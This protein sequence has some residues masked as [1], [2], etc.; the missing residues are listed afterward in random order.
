[1][2]N[3]FANK[4]EKPEDDV[5][6]QAQ[7]RMHETAW[8][9]ARIGDITPS[10][11]A[12]TSVNI[13]PGNVGVAIRWGKVLDDPMT[14]GWQLKM[15]YTDVV[16]LSTKLE[17]HHFEMETAS[18]DLQVVTTGITVPYS[19]DPDLAPKVYQK[20]GGPKEIEAAIITPAILES[21]K[22][23]NSKYTAEEL[24][25]KRAEVKE[26]LE[27]AFD[28]FVNK[29]LDERGLHNAL[30]L[31][32]LAITDSGFTPEFNKAIEAKVQADQAALQAQYEKRA[33]ITAAEAQAEKQKLAAD[34]QAY[35]IAAT[36]RA[37]AE[38]LA[39]RARAYSDPALIQLNA[40]EKWNGQLPTTMAG[41]APLP[42]FNIDLPAT[43]GSAGQTKNTEAK[44]NKFS[45]TQL[46]EMP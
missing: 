14:E 11:W 34:A 28:T 18:K 31:G 24:V 3:V 6:S 8:Q 39:L 20:I 9:Q 46:D 19:L 16:Q 2:D 42:F 12:G 27:E 5:A 15:P 4:A 38:S 41:N 29:A 33:Q 43:A 21:T 26:K 36:G 32:S 35:M 37:E 45:F 7:S 30:H 1:M 25:T 17:P 40:I 22:A 10:S 44:S 23:V 13:G